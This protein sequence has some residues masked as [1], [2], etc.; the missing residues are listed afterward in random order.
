M[1]LDWR[2]RTIEPQVLRCVSPKPYSPLFENNRFGPL[3]LLL[4]NN[5]QFSL[6]QQRVECADY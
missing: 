6:N 1:R 2:Q 4:S 3:N 5:H